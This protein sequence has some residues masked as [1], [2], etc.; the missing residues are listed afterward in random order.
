MPDIKIRSYFLLPDRT[1]RR[2][3]P[4]GRAA[5]PDG[6]RGLP[7]AEAA[8]GAERARLRRAAPP[9][10]DS[11]EGRRTGSRWTQPQKHWIQAIMGED[12][13]VPFPYF[14]DVSSWSNPLLMGI[15][16]VYTGDDVKPKAELVREIPAAGRP[17][18][19]AR[20]ALHVP[21]RL[22]AGRGVHLPAARSR[23][24]RW[25]VT[26][27]SSVVAIPASRLIRHR[28]TTLHRVA[29]RDPRPRAEAPDRHQPRPAATSGSSQGTGISTTSGSHGEA[30]Y[31]LG[32][33]WGLDL[34]AGHHGRHQRQHRGVHRPRRCCW[35]PT[36][37][38]RPAA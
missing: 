19:M 16:T 2:R 7:D 27:T 30:R 12:P 11:A 18:A 25:T 5:A 8:Q 20:G 3:P 37:A 23:R 34:H 29:R 1:A 38:A 22:G 21:A 36:A 32:K 33:R 10:P 24:T 14:Y 28:S 13:Y 17:R 26:W 35:S 31:V 15:N 4:A 9:E 6:R